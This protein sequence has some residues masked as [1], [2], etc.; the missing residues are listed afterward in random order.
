M[1]M[2]K[3]YDWG[4][5]ATHLHIALKQEFDLFNN[6]LF[7]YH[8][9]QLLPRIQKVVEIMQDKWGG[10]MHVSIN[11]D[12]IRIKDDY[13]EI[14]LSSLEVSYLDVPTVNYE[15][16]AFHG[17]LLMEAEGY[18]ITSFT[19]G[20]QL[21][22]NILTTLASD[23]NTQDGKREVLRHLSNTGKFSNIILSE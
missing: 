20:R 19:D 10:E 4:V 3:V 14:Q 17:Q 13:F 9:E 15:F 8:H 23:A 16:E 7:E 11:G 5:P 2:I 6:K 12:N 1:F 18:K 22:I 21:V